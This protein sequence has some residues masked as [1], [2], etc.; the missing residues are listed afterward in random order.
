MTG[1][2][3]QSGAWILDLTLG[4]HFTHKIQFH[5]FNLVRWLFPYL[6]IKKLRL[7]KRK[8]AHGWDMF[9]PGWE[10]NREARLGYITSLFDKL[11]AECKVSVRVQGGKQK[12]LRAFQI[13]ISFRDFGTFE[14]TGR[15]YGAGS[16]FLD[17]S[18]N[19]AESTYREGVCLWATLR[20]MSE[21]ELPPL[22][23]LSEE[24]G[25]WTTQIFTQGS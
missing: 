23:Q 10:P 14:S 8:W 2:V 1:C 9:R 18:Q 15:A 20:D 4:R 11:Y 17:E 12:P 24:S 22:P 6:E 25:G 19:D 3:W 7:G 16:S 21:Q 13:R 5:I